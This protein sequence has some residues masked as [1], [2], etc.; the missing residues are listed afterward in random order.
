MSI[1]ILWSK[2]CS[3]NVKR[4]HKLCHINRNQPI[5][6]EEAEKNHCATFFLIKNETWHSSWILLLFELLNSE[7]NGKYSELFNRR[8][9]IKKKRLPASK[10]VNKYEF[11][12]HLKVFQKR[13]ND[14]IY[15]MNIWLRRDFVNRA[16]KRRITYWA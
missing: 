3:I 15:Q 4:L 16:F 12:M 10:F 5:N 9:E 14:S 13:K 6:R 8:T 2:F 11:T 1:E 7:I